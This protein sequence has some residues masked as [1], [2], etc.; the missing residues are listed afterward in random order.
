VEN[1]SDTA[2]DSL[3]AERV[4]TVNQ[5]VA[6]N[7]ARYRRAEGLTQQGLA[8]RLG[9]PQNKVSE[10][11]RSWDGKRTREFDAQVLTELCEALG[12]PL[13]AL[14]LPPEDPEYELLYPG[15]G[16]RGLSGMPELMKLIMPETGEDGPAVNTFRGRFQ[17]AAGKYLH[18]EW[19]AEAAV[20]LRRAEPREMSAARRTRM[21][22]LLPGLRAAIREFEDIADIIGTELQEGQ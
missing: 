15:P 3:P 5:I 6:W 18:E 11:E 22:A 13:L 17:I 20:L 16:G 1:E 19:A 8:S 2:P 10:A 7:I 21:L 14:F 4:V 9:W 12:V